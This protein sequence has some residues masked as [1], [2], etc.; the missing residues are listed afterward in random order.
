MSLLFKVSFRTL[1]TLIVFT[2]KREETTAEANGDM[3]PSCRV[4][5]STAQMSL[6]LLGRQIQYGFFSAS[7][8]ISKND[9]SICLMYRPK[10]K[11]LH[12][13]LLY[14][15]FDCRGANILRFQTLILFWLKGFSIFYFSFK[16][17]FQYF[18]T[19]ARCL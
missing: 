2:G 18:S 15:Q 8:G 6:S 5:I 14:L 11:G 17:K 13:H 10:V 3:T 4:N 9:S 12:K 19:W 16:G 7:Q 1:Q